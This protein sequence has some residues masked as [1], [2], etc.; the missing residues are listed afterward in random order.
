M[1]IFQALENLLINQN[2]SISLRETQNL[3]QGLRE[4]KKEFET[5]ESKIDSLSNKKDVEAKKA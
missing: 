5:M 3:I 2:L 4:K 1:D